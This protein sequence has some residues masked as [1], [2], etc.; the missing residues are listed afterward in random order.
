MLFDAKPYDL[1][2]AFLKWFAVVGASAVVA[3]LVGLVISLLTLGKGGTSAVKDTL[4]RGFDDLTKLSPRR[5]WALGY[6]ALKESLARRA[7]FVLGT[8]IVLFMAANLFLRTP[9]QDVPA[10]PYVSFV[11]TVVQWILIPVALLLACWGLPADIKDRSLHTVVTKPVRRSEIVI[12]RMLGYGLMT[13]FVLLVV[14]V[15]G[16][17]WIMRVVPER[18]QSQLIS[19]VPVFSS[20]D[21]PQDAFYFIDR[22]GNRQRFGTNVGDIWDF[23]SYIEGQTNSRAVWNFQA[24]GV[25]SLSGDKLRMEYRFEAFRSHK[26]NIDENEGVRFRLFFVNDEK[27]LRVPYPQTAA[28]TRSKSLPRRPSAA[29]PRSRM[30][31]RRCC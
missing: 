25:G 10:K 27:K 14:A 5:I 13:T 2:M 1:G 6:L 3:L 21:N 11:L 24:L 28:G 23:R 18:A 9:E 29:R 26:G 17:I 19:R 8:F 22:A 31:N 7:L 30:Q 4:K 20:A 15:F 12:G 16:W